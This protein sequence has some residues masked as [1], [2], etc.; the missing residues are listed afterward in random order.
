VVQEEAVRRVD[1]ATVL[2]AQERRGGRV[3]EN[4]FTA[5]LVVTRII[6]YVAKAGHE[7]ALEETLKRSLVGKVDLGWGSITAAVVDDLSSRQE[8]ILGILRRQ[9]GVWLSGFRIS[10][11]EVRRGEQALREDREP[12]PTYEQVSARVL[13]EFEQEHQRSMAEPPKTA[14]PTP[15]LE[16]PPPAPGMT[17]PDQGPAFDDT[18]AA[19]ATG[20]ITMGGYEF[21]YTIAMSLQSF[22]SAIEAE[23]MERPR[24]LAPDR[25][26]RIA[27]AI[28]HYIP[29]DWNPAPEIL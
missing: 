24:Y 12:G 26:L 19:L 5:P 7:T 3:Q 17:V 6:Q 1:Q 14:P 22:V 18:D 15:P 25:C 16:V 2:T 4:V 21:A 28:L 20:L 9:P 27:S 10:D 11:T 8:D 13:Q 29:D 23:T